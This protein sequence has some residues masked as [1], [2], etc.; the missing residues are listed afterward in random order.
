M[1]VG[2]GG[3]GRET[4][5]VLEAVGQMSPTWHLLG[6]LDDAPAETD[7]ERIYARGMR[8]LGSTQAWLD[9]GNE[10]S[11]VVGVGAPA[12]RRSIAERFELA[13]LTAA[14]LIHPRAQ[15]G[16][17]TRIGLGSVVCAGA[18]IS[19]NVTIGR[20]VHLNPNST[21]GHDTELGDF[22]S[23]NPGAVISGDCR[24]E[25][26][27]LVGA[28]GTVLQGLVVGQGAIVGAS[29][30]VVRDVPPRTT[31]KGVPAR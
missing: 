13:G 14:T 17:S 22:V 7:L 11:Y 2:V 6:V 20:H 10:A 27:S 12:T 9:G 29:A 23:I 3:F 15:A 30:C 19:T 18:V 24:V 21:I 26:E 5:D 31:V 28:S 8:F 25:H 4:L 1:V 16:T